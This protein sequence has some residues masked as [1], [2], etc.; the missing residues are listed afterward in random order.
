MEEKVQQDD[1]HAPDVA[2]SELSEDSFPFTI[3]F[4][5]KDNDE[6]VLTEVVTRPGAIVIPPLAKQLGVAVYITVSYPDGHIVVA[7]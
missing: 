1:R 4:F 2:F 7:G 3:K 6:L 5:R